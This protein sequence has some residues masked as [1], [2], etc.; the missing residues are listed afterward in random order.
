MQPLGTLEERIRASRER[1]QTRRE[2]LELLA[3][4]KAKYEKK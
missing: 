3:K 4:L 2:E 1:E